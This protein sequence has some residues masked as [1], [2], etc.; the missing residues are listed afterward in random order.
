MLNIGNIRYI[1][2]FAKVV[3]AGSFTAAGRALNMSTATTSLHV[4]R[5]E[6]NLG[7]ALLYRNTRKLSLTNEGE[8]LYS[9]SSA[10]M[11][12]YEKE[13][14]NKDW[15]QLGKAP[16]KFKIAIPAI[17]V[18]SSLLTEISRFFSQHPD[19]QVA[20]SCN[21]NHNDIVGEAIDIAVRLGD[22]PDSSLKARQLFMVERKVVGTGDL[23]D[24]LSRIE[25]PSQLES[26][27]WIGLSMRRNN[28]RFT[29]VSGEQCEI[30]YT[31]N[32]VVDS[33]EASYRLACHGVG[34]AA[35]PA[36]LI[37]ERDEVK[38]ILTDWRLEPLPAYAIWPANISSGS[39]TYELIEHLKTNCKTLSL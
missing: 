37:D 28:R 3:E 36:F 12:L 17:L 18:R 35:P 10:I 23:S 9:S 19:I 2:V 33:V 39:I 4:S 8:N 22:L 30:S 25:H 24:K 5:L 27:R 26:L 7:V 13:F 16:R 29:H 20:L 1:L 32:F 38:P 21:D 34:I 31:P 11:E 14:A 6:E 15:N